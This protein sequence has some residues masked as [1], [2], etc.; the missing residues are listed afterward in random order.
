MIA[1]IARAN[2]YT[3]CIF[4]NLNANISFCKFIASAWPHVSNTNKQEVTL[5]NFSM[6]SDI[7]LSIKEYFC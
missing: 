1:F 4:T 2:R 7:F 3:H 5:L 6:L